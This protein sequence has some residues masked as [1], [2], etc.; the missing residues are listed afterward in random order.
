MQ[1]MTKSNENYF[2]NVFETGLLSVSTQSKYDWSLFQEEG[3]GYFYFIE[4]LPATFVKTN[5]QQETG[6][7]LS[8]LFDGLLRAS[9]LTKKDIL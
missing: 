9:K 3:N 8:I 4:Q 7:G 1:T 2:T 6:M 5:G